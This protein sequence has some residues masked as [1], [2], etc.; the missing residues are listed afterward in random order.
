[1]PTASDTLFVPLDARLRFKLSP[2]AASQFGFRTPRVSLS[3]LGVAAAMQ[4]RIRNK[5]PNALKDAHGRPAAPLLP[6]IKESAV[7]E[8][9]RAV[10]AAI[11]TRPLPRVAAFAGGFID[12][13]NARRGRTVRCGR[14]GQTIKLS[15]M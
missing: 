12:I 8:P 10:R 7:V 6:R 1:M 5:D 3:Q 13:E 11:S 4:A 14:N 9:M 2:T 15:W